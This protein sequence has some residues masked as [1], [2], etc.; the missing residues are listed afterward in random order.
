M[1][2]PSP[3][4]ATFLAHSVELESEAGE[5]YGELADSMETHR[6]QPVAEFFRRMEAEAAQHLEEVAGLAGDTPL[7]QLTA[8]EFEWPEAEPPETASYEAVHYRMSLRQA[9]ELAL[10]NERAAEAYYRDYAA[11]SGDRE[12]ISVATRFAEEESGHAAELMRILAGLPENGAHQ[13]EEDDEPAMP[14]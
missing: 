14:E 11:G 10:A 4:L 1:N 7:P 6:N 5:R 3:E 2:R 13:L 9:V 12:T 8:W